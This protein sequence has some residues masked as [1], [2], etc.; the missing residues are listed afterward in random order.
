MGEADD[1]V[2]IA[3]VQLTT[4][5]VLFEKCTRAGGSSMKCGPNDLL[6][7]VLMLVDTSLE[8]I[9]DAIKIVTMIIKPFRMKK[10]KKLVKTRE[11]NKKI[12]TKQRIF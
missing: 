6:P 8:D 7:P 4:A 3:A 1:P 11:E 9:G 10:G 5:P 2:A 12:E